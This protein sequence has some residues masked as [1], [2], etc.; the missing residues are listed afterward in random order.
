MCPRAAVDRSSFCIRVSA[1]IIIGA[2]HE[3]SPLH[4]SP[5]NTY[6][7]REQLQRLAH[8]RIV[9]RHGAC[10]PAPACRQGRY[11]CTAAA[12]AGHPGPCRTATAMALVHCAPPALPSGRGAC[13]ADP[14]GVAHHRQLQ[15]TRPP[16]SSSSAPW[17]CTCRR[18]TVLYCTAVTVYGVY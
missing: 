2:M 16:A 12:G 13:T 11:I 18:V 17:Q 14:A 8:T 4:G 1:R 15:S 6:A 7:A 9:T 5:R 10:S 3:T